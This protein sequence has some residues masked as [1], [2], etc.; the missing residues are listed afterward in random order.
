MPTQLIPIEF[1]Q[2]MRSEVLVT[3]MNRARRL[4]QREPAEILEALERKRAAYPRMTLTDA[5]KRV[6]KDLEIS[7][8]T[9]VRATR[10]P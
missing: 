9:V 8:K 3:P 5:R 1:K 10:Q 6:A 4:L 7:Y 2:V